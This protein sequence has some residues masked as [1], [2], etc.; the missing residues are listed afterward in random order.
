MTSEQY[1]EYY[2]SRKSLPIAEKM[3]KAFHRRLF[4]LAVRQIPGL[5]QKKF[6]EVGVGWGHLAAVCRAEAVD[7]SGVELNQAQADHLKSLGY[8]V[9][10]AHVPPFPGGEAVDVIWLSHLLEHMDGFAAARELLLAA[11]KKLNK[12]GYLVIISP[13]IN[14]WKEAFWEVDW[15][16]GYPTSVQRISQLLQDTGF[17]IHFATTITTTLP[18]SFVTLLLD[19]VYRCLPINLLDA[20][21][22]RLTG[23]KLFFSYMS[24]FGWRQAYVI[25]E[26]V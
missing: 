21:A 26:K 13:D 6:F 14:S 9:A 1:S 12:G 11:H 7:Y 4:Q 17:K 20:L 18:A 10:C 5:R 19:L 8:N 23:K 15:S 3:I 2:L 16:H 25:G 22:V 24:L